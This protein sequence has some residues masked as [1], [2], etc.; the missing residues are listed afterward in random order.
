[1]RLRKS[2]HQAFMYRLMATT[3]RWRSAPLR[4][5]GSTMRPRSYPT[6]TAYSLRLTLTQPG[7]AAAKWWTDKGAIRLRPGG[8]KDP[9]EMYAAGGAEAVVSWYISALSLERD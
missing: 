1:M 8:A 4:V 3:T 2:T 5:V 7:D 6:R 9:G